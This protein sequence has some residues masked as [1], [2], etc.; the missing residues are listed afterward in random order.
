MIIRALQNEATSA[1]SASVASPTHKPWE[2]TWTFTARIEPR[3]SNSRTSTVPTRTT[4]LC[5]LLSSVHQFTLNRLLGTTRF[6]VIMSI[7]RRETII[8]RIISHLGL[9]LGFMGPRMMIQGLHSLTKTFGVR[10][11]A[12]GS[13]RPGV[14]T[15]MISEWECGIMKKWIWSFV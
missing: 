10:I 14:W 4:Y 6:W 15:M 1:H 2:D 5:L 7:I 11:W 13:V 12:W 8:R 3:P 9:A